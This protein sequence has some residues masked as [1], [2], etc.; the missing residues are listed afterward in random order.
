MTWSLLLNLL[1]RLPQGLLSRGTGWVA[2]LR[3]PAFLRGPVIGGF[4]RVAG[5]DTAEAEAPPEAYPSVGA[6]FARRL[7]PGVRAWPADEGAVVSPVDGVVGAMGSLHAGR[8]VQAKGMDYDAGQLLGDAEEA[9][10]FEGGCFLTIYLSP[11]HYHRIHTPVAGRIRLARALPGR[12]LPVNLAAVRSIPELFPTNERLVIQMER[13]RRQGFAGEGN[14]EEGYPG[15]DRPPEP[16]IAW[17]AGKEAAAP[18]AAV[19][20]VA[21]G[22]FNVGRISA[23]FDP[24]W[25]TNRPRR[26][27]PGP[28]TRR[29]DLEVGPGAELAAFHLGS[30]V[31]LLFAPGPGGEAPPPFHPDV[32]PGD[33]IRVGAPLF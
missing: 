23:A 8:L 33:E 30:T 18:G 7:R 29:Y 26:E 22:A 3:L 9:D 2:D 28:E 31:V 20:L 10:L 25:V 21:V 14:P 32:L 4:A 5:I 12:L 11:R 1:K 16:G 17:S 27:R 19:A 15:D 24:G 13:R 6:F